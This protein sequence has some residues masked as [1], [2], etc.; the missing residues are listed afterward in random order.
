MFQDAAHENIARWLPQEV[1]SQDILNFLG[2]KGLY[3]QTVA[4]TLET[5]FLEQARV[6]EF[7]RQKRQTFPAEISRQIPPFVSRVSRDPIEAIYLLLNGL[8]P[9]GITPLPDN[10]GLI[11]APLGSFQSQEKLMGSPLK[12]C[13]LKIDLGLDEIQEISAAADEI[14]L[15]PI[16]QNQ[17]VKLEI[18][19]FGPLNL[20]NQTDCRLTTKGGELG[21]VLD[22]RGR[23]LICPENNEQGRFRLNNWKQALNL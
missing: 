6:I 22:F 14:L 23:P 9:V 16:D 1:S 13:Q 4:E 10:L 8:E 3:P 18:N 11:I 7:L 5:L 2:N 12:A 19:L 20:A 21:I 15:L 17:E